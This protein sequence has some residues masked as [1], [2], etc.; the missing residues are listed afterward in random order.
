MPRATPTRPPSN[1]I[2]PSILRR[3]S[4]SITAV[5]PDPRNT[6]VSSIQIVFNKPVTGF[7]LS[8]L[9]LKLNVGANL[10]TGAQTLNSADNMTWTL[11]NLAGDHR[12]R[13]NLRSQVDGCRFKHSGFDGHGIELRRDREL[14]DGHHGAQRQCDG[15][16]GA[17]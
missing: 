13:G 12:R 4:A 17:I 6:A 16:G 2:E 15:G 9:T 8:D 1:S 5:A 11:G 7:D 10:L 3:S 14:G